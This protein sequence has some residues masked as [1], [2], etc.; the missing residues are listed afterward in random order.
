MADRYNNINNTSP[1]VS[2]LKNEDKKIPRSDFDY[3]RSHHGNMN[4]GTLEILDCFPTLPNS[5]YTI[6]M[7]L[8]IK[9]NTNF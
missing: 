3:G 9:C 7:D 5:D 8:L 4:I 6:A 1:Y 2:A